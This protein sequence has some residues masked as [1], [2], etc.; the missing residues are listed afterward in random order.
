M[1]NPN[2]LLLHLA[3]AVVLFALGT[4]TEGQPTSV[5]EP[6]RVEISGY[7][8]DVMEPFLSRDGE[9]LLFNNRNQPPNETD[10]HL[11]RR[12]EDPDR[13]TYVGK[14]AGANSEQLDA[15]ASL[16]RMGNLYFT[17]TREYG[18]TGNTL[19]TA[20]FVNGIVTGAKPVPGTYRRRQPPWLNMDA[21]VSSDGATLYYTENRFDQERRR[22]ATSDILMAEKT[23][24][25]FVQKSSSAE[26]LANVNSEL[27][28]Y[29]P[30][31]TADELSLFFTRLDLAKVDRGRPG[32]AF[33]IWL[34][35]RPS[36]DAAF[37]PPARIEGL[38]GVVEAVTVTPDGCAIYFH[39]RV[40]ARFL[41]R[42]A[43]LID[44]ATP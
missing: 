16:D 6:E 5:L 18:R 32:E 33:S 11:A 28:E 21:E 8:G 42:R 34:S 9:W 15:V 25:G 26:L 17:S 27:M 38:R 44:C 19:W 37:G 40:G 43:S 22:V 39:Q 30:S 31:T 41:L 7:D 3:I 12:S 36:K 1:F 35:V 2:R 20:R 29:A 24:D 14:L 10:L 4:A 13:F 23:A